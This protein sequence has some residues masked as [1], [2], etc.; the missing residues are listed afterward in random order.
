MQLEHICAME[1]IYSDKFLL[2]RPYGG[3]GG[4]GY[5]EGDGPLTVM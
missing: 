5:G 1:L 4:T 3:E 2:V